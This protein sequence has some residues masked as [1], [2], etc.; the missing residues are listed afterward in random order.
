MKATNF[1]VTSRNVLGGARQQVHL[2]IGLVL[3]LSL[4]AMTASGQTTTTVQFAA[5]VT[6]PSGGIVLTGTGI[7]P[8]TGQ[9]FRHFWGG[10]ETHGLCRYDPDLDS[11]GPYAQNVN[12]CINFVG[13]VQFKPGEM[14][15]DPN[16]NNLYAP[17]IQAGADATYRIPFNP[18][19]DSGHGILNAINITVLITNNAGHAGGPGCTTTLVAANSTALGPDGNLYVASLRSGNVVRIIAP[20]TDPLPCTNVQ[21]DVIDSPDGRKNFGLGWIGH[22]LFGGDGFSAWEMRNADQC[23]TAAN[24]FVTCTAQNILA[25]QLPVPTA[26][27]SDQNFPNLDGLNLYYTNGST[28]S[29]V[30]IVNGAVTDINTSYATNFSLANGLGVDTK[31]PQA[32][33]LFVGD[34]PSAGNQP[35]SGHWWQVL[36]QA[37]APA[38]PGA[39][40]N[41]TAVAGNAQATVSWTSAP[42]G[43][44]ITSFTVHNSFA[45]NGVLVP[46]VIVGPNPGTTVVPT[47]V[48]VTGLTNGVTYQ[49]E[50]AA[51]DSVGTGPFSAPSNSVTPFAPTVPSAP[52][53][54]SATA[55]DASA[56]VAWTASASN[57]GSAITGY[58]VTARV[59]GTPSGITA[60]CGSTCTGANVTGLS[61][62]TT[63][64]FTVH[65][66]NGIGNS[67]E[68]AP[69][70]AVTPQINAVPQD[71]SVTDSGPASVNSGANATYAIKVNNSATSTIPDAIL[72]DTWPTTGG[73]TFVSVTPSQG[74]C[75]SAAGNINCNLGAIAGSG[76]ATV[77]LALRLTA[78]TT[79]TAKVSMKDAAGNPIADPTPADDTASATT[80][81]TAPQ[82]TTDVQ[83]T[84]SAANGGPAVGSADTL[85]WQIHNAQ[86]QA[87]NALSFTITMSPGTTLASVNTS[88]GT[89]TGPALGTSG[90][91]TCT[92]PSL[93]AA[94][95]MIVTENVNVVQAGSLATT[96]TASFSGTDTNPANNSFT[97]TL[98]AK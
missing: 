23:F 66:T 77:T 14:S 39:P 56:Q 10:D 89:C 38:L 31:N 33:V 80:S 74:T 79:N 17:N 18:S 5:N 19:G 69:S 29:R 37:V 55:G 48:V 6:I 71:A 88:V 62:G 11:P 40:T 20:A 86:N 54:V 81:I 83:V 98:N 15:F 41:V 64:T 85:T 34:D 58:T 16:T 97:V 8:T 92:A 94:A 13:S 51:T 45:S 82:T 36:P 28:V 70:N 93:A 75:T 84:G 4:A 50:V 46:D 43:Q 60:T 27:K 95:T 90:T 91:I 78:Q 87:A 12:T 68:S 44:T 67:P 2:W 73:A 96:G 32:E 52:T 49:F 47:S 25:G 30:Q 42:D 61:N 76:S 1:Q 59:N 21:N 65:A 53:N 63:Y 7:N 26:M 35:L 3:M 9:P 22:D 57:G 24:N 72:S